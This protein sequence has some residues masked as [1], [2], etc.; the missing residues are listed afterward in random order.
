L[1]LRTKLSR[2]FTLGELI[3]SS[4]AERLGIPNIP[5]AKVIENLETT[6]T[7][8]LQPVRDWAQVP[9]IVTSGFRSPEL[10]RA[11]K[12]SER[13]QH[14]TGHAVDFEVPGVS[15]YDVAAWVRDNLE[16]DQLILEFYTPGIPDSGWV[17]ASFVT[18]RMNRQEV[19][20]IGKGIRK[21]G[22]YK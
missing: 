3:K 9:V 19:L 20:T 5:S 22:L 18:D 16:F 14:M 10:N 12:G 2:N 4:T 7:M 1:N 17:H 15:N 6:A 11:I 8:I 21:L 13:S